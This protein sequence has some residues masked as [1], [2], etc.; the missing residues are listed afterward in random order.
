MLLLAL[1]CN[2]GFRNPLMSL[3]TRQVAYERN[4]A[5][6]EL[7]ALVPPD[8]AVAATNSLGPRLA[9]RER[10]YVFPGDDI[11][12]PVAYAER[13]DYLAIDSAE[14]DADDRAYFA[15]VRASGRYRLI[16]QHRYTERG[17]QQEL[18]LWQR[19]DRP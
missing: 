8:A 14:L 17:Q 2:L 19:A 18:S 9:Q 3:L 5:A 11:I 12:Y 7:V 15:G 4:Q 10:L 13:A 6:A 16:A 1:A